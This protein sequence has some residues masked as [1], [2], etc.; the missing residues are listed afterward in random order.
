[1]AQ[2]GGGVGAYINS[3]LKY[4]IL[5]HEVT[6]TESLWLET[7]L[8]GR[9]ITVGII[10]RKPNTD[11]DQFQNSLLLTLKRLK[12]DKANVVLL[13]DFNINVLH[14]EGID[15]KAEQ[16]LTSLQCLGMQ[17]LITSPTRVTKTTSSLIDHVYTNVTISSIHAGVI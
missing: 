3:S 9:K 16:F 7:D 15:M 8:N 12:I 1:M 11:I 13:G 17:Q 10:Y 4:V 2:G 6:P 5:D 14:K